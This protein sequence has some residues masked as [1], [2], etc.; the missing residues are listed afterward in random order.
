MAITAA[1]DQCNTNLNFN[2]IKLVDREAEKVVVG[3]E[4]CSFTESLAKLLQGTR[5]IPAPGWKE[6]KV[7]PSPLSPHAVISRRAGFLCR[8]PVKK[9][10]MF[11]VVKGLC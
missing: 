5:L 3:G 2:N 6:E 4:R 11:L 9:E 8:R 1:I 7:G 10:M